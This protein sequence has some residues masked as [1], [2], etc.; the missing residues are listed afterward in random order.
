M[1]RLRHHLQLAEGA[2][3]PSI[4][5][6]R[7]TPID[8]KPRLNCPL[9]V[10]D[11]KA[12]GDQLHDAS[13]I[14]DDAAL[15]DRRPVVFLA[16]SR[17]VSLNTADLSRGL[18]GRCCD[19]SPAAWQPGAC[20]PRQGWAAGRVDDLERFQEFLEGLLIGVVILPVAEIRHEVF[21]DSLN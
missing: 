11:D 21:T 2:T 12:I 4:R 8:R 9:V 13:S 20:V 6:V 3:V 14:D 16:V 19:F 1:R 10:Y 5:P 7:P 17:S 15:Q 18:N